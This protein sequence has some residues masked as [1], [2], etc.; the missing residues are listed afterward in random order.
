MLVCDAFFIGYS[1]DTFLFEIS[2][3]PSEN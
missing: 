1:V 2:V 3:T